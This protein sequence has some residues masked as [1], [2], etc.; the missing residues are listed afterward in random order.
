[1][2][3]DLIV[4]GG[5]PAGMMAAGRAAENGARVLLLEKN[6]QLGVKL[7]ITGKGRCNIT[8]T[9]P[10]LKKFI[11]QY[12]QNGKFLF[13][14]LNKFSPQD[15]LLFFDN[16]G[17]A[18]K[19]ERGQ[20][21]FPASDRADA[22]LSALIKYLK[23]NQ[24]ETRLNV[25]VEKIVTRLRDKNS[26]EKIIL[27]NGQELIAKNYLIATGG[28]SYPG[29]GS[30]GTG[31]EWLKKMGHHII[32][33][34]PAL[35][36]IVVQEPWIHELEGLSLKNVAISLYQNNKKMDSRFGEAI[37]TH[38]G[39][40]GPIILDM[41]KKIG[42]LLTKG[43]VSLKIDFKPALDEKTLD[44]RIQEDFL[45]FKDKM[46]KNSLA[47]LL[48]QKMVPVII[49]L[50]GIETNKKVNIINKIER[51]KL[52]GL[53]KNFTLQVKKT[54]GFGAAIIT[55]GGVDLKEIDP[56]TMR[57]KIIDNLYLSGEILDLDGPTGGFNLQ[58]C[59]ST[60]YVAGNGIV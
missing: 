38:N 26:I 18:T 43:V 55:A 6:D 13:T 25:E 32:Q 58:V 28:K 31:F 21:V 53:L 33:P 49:K 46:F 59:W 35:V 30:T 54:A 45:N 42:E 44:Q 19:V 12:G 7:L 29:T 39:L 41:G 36:P 27:T 1:M 50:S 17:V 15:T 52:L 47:W 37:F 48:P 24:V 11:G 23:K 22:V 2:L 5:G 60:G 8:N 9:E 10:E 20:R 4:I 16:L 34:Q 40:S 14:A 3:Y 56:Q 51:Q 57:S